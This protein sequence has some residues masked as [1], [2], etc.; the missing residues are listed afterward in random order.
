[1]SEQGISAL[2]ERVRSDEGFRQRLEAA[3]TNEAKRQIVQDAGFD[4]DRSDLA[5]LRSLT[6]LQELSDADLEKVAGGAGSATDIATAA[7]GSAT[8]AAATVAATLV[9]AALVM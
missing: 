8:G 4:V 5:P 9:A 6:G 7:V 1:M 2:L 3:P